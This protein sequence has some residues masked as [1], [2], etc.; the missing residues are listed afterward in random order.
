M[1]DEKPRLCDICKQVEVDAAEGHVM[2][3]DCFERTAAIARHDPWWFA[4]GR[5]APDLTRVD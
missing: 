5:E 2:C 3:P 1:S 4:E